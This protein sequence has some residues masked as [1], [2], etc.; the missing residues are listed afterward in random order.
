MERP[1]RVLTRPFRHEMGVHFTPPESGHW[2]LSFPLRANSRHLFDEIVGASWP[3]F[4]SATEGSKALD[5]YGRQTGPSVFDF[6]ADRYDCLCRSQPDKARKA[7]ADSGANS[8]GIRVNLGRPAA[9]RIKEKKKMA[10]LLHHVRR[11]CR[12]TAS[13]VVPPRKSRH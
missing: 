2:M 12:G 8:G 7:I 10:A 4:C 6:Y 3:A 9:R 11:G 13:A 1:L 5:F